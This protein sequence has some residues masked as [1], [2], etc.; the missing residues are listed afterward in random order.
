MK[1]YLIGHSVISMSGLEEFFADR[2]MKWAPEGHDVDLLP[3]FYGRL[4]YMSFDGT[5]NKNITKMREGNQAY[6]DN[7]LKVGHGSVLEHSSFNFVFTDVSRVLTHELVR[8]RQGT[9]ISQESGRY[10]RS[11]ADR[12]EGMFIPPELK[13]N[14]VFAS[15]MGKVIEANEE[16][17]TEL[18]KMCETA[19]MHEKKQLTSAGRRLMP[20]GMRNTI[21]WTCNARTLRF[22]LQ[23]RTD[24]AAEVEIRTLFNMVYDQVKHL[25]CMKCETEEHNG[26]LWI[27]GGKV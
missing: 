17:Q 25:N 26:L 27:K 12:I 5:D 3:E 22:V 18:D 14:P 21:G 15:S 24:P 10:I 19:G 1:S 20:I 13:D 23:Q 16:F 2:G 4:C 9:A 7:I 6:L 11:G 8:H